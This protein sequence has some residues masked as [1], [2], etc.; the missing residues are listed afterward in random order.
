MTIA[1]PNRRRRWHSPNPFCKL[2][3]VGHGRRKH[4]D[5]DVGRQKDQHFLPY[6][7]PLAE[8]REKNFQTFQQNI[9]SHFGDW[10]IDRYLLITT[11]TSIE[12]HHVVFI[13]REHEQ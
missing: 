8:G 3:G 4:D 6:H 13:R 7:P 1:D 5:L 11:T 10:I 2:P 12:Q 9:Q